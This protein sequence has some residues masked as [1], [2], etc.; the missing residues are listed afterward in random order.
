[1]KFDEIEVGRIYCVPRGHGLD[2]FRATSKQIGP[3][4]VAFQAFFLD[5]NDVGNDPPV[6]FREELV[7]EPSVWEPWHPTA[8]LPPNW[9]EYSVHEAKGGTKIEEMEVGSLYFQMGGDPRPIGGR[10]PVF[11][12]DFI[13]V[14]E[15]KGLSVQAEI[16]SVPFHG[17][18]PFDRRSSIFSDPAV[19]KWLRPISGF[20][21]PEWLQAILRKWPSSARRFND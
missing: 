8:N 6:D 21:H 15:K 17:G 3:E 11:L 7:T 19:V 10:D 20:E 16:V 5:G 4:A 14:V 2:F 1:M 12:W 9:W 13:R 18:Y